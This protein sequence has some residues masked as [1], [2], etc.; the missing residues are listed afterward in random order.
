MRW[1]Q[2]LI[3]ALTY[4]LLGCFYC[5]G[6][7]DVR[8]PWQRYRLVS[9]FAEGGMTAASS[10]DLRAEAGA[11]SSVLPFSQRLRVVV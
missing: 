2:V 4:P 3:L 7:P 10:C 9:T 5:C 6:L 8:W 11:R 1:P